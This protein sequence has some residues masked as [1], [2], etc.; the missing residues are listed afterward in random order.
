M[1]AS[2]Q[3][4]T[5]DEFCREMDRLGLTQLGAAELM[6]VNDRTIRRWMRGERPI[7]PLVSTFLATV[8]P[9]PWADDGGARTLIPP[10]PPG[11]PID[12]GAAERLATALAA[13]DAADAALHAAADAAPASAP[14]TAA[15]PPAATTLPAKPKKPPT[16]RRGAIGGAIQ[17][18]GKA[19]DG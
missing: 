17:R 11:E 14:E 5:P 6:G 13:A 9:R 19:A 12:D 2:T 4:M 18:R 10:H 15:E 3:R 16:G 7:P 8:D 1:L